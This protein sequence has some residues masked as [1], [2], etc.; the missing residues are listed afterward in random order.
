MDWRCLYGKERTMKFTIKLLIVLVLLLAT[1]SPQTTASAKTYRFRTADYYLSTYDAS[2]C[3]GSYTE[4]E[5]GEELLPSLQIYRYDRCQNQPL[6]EAYGRKEL[7]NSEFKFSGNLDSATLRTTV[8]MYDYVT[9]STFDVW[10]DLTWTGTGEIHSSRDHYNDQPSPGCH[11]NRILVE[12]YRSASAS[13]TISDGTTN[14]TPEP[15]DQANLY[16]AKRTETSHG[17]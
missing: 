1:F 11:V 4:L 2:G 3:I 14:F 12:E 6:M 5:V 8:P 15:A 9:D 10:V 7:T 16:F 13:G 17:C